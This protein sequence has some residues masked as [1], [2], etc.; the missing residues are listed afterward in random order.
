MAVSFSDLQSQLRAKT[1]PSTVM[2]QQQQR[3]APTP[4]ASMTIPMSSATN[5]RAQI[6]R[7]AVQDQK[8]GGGTG[9]AKTTTGGGTTQAQAQQPTQPQFF[10]GTMPTGPSGDEMAAIE[11]AYGAGMN[12][13]QGVESRLRPEFESALQEAES[14]Y[15]TQAKALG[16]QRET[17]MGQ[18][19]EQGVKGQQAYESA[20]AQARQMYE[21]LQRGYQQ[22]F[23]GASSA[24]Q[25][26][27]E[28]A[29]VE[30]LRQQGQNYRTLQDVNRQL[31]RS[32]MDV[33]NQYNTNLMQLEQNKIAAQNQARR[34]FNDRLSQIEAQR[35]QL[36]QNKAA[37]KLQALQNLRQQVLQIEAENRN[38]QNTLAL[39]RE[40]ARMNLETYRQQ[41]AAGTGAALQ[42]TTTQLNNLANTFNNPNLSV[43]ERTNALNQALPLI[44]S[45][46][47]SQAER[48]RFRAT[49]GLAPQQ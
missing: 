22:R 25:A 39:Q 49:F 37:Q 28:I 29:N 33:E 7:P 4:V 24:G 9:G 43:Q 11:E 35:G 23:G 18:L 20:L 44:G 2:A 10:A 14:I 46:S 15:G 45:M 41:L 26:A 5:P 1:F 13:L 42:S 36:A 3:A 6:Y 34:E 38:F 47:I 12:Y 17:A 48:D 27:T 8:T 16:G 40:Q 19:Q 31:E 32:R 21:Q 30:R